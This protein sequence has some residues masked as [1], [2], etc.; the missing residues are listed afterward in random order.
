VQPGLEQG[1]QPSIP[2]TYI[3]NSLVCCSTKWLGQQQQGE[4]RYQHGNRCNEST[5]SIVHTTNHPSHSS[6]HD[7]STFVLLIL[8]VTNHSIVIRLY[9]LNSYT[10]NDFNRQMILEEERKE[11][12]TE[13]KKEEEEERK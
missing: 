12:Q 4:A 2:P 1:R 10:N 5:E 6:C 13:R 8:L 7:H 11:R 3:I 9:E